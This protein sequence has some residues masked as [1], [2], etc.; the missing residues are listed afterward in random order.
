MAIQTSKTAQV[1]SMLTKD[2]HTEPRSS[3][4]NDSRFFPSS[5]GAGMN[6][7]P[8]VNVQIQSANNS[9][10]EKKIHDSLSAEL[11]I[12]S[13]SPADTKP[14]VTNL[15]KSGG[16]TFMYT[17]VMEEIVKDKVLGVMFSYN[18]CTC[19]RCVMDTMALALTKLPS[20]YVVSDGDD[21]FP[22][23]NFYKSQYNTSVMTALSQAC[24][25][26]SES[27]HH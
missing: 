1:L 8:V 3:S 4:Y 27:P 24:Q 21:N 2:K 10:L 15:Y 5:R 26:V 9:S 12:S 23:L 22:L 17:N 13:S 25:K 18:M 16:S 7:A 19:S 6:N 20:K 11:G 14:T